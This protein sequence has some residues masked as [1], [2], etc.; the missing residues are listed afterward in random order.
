VAK[1]VRLI[2]S[3]S[4]QLVFLDVRLSDGLGFDVLRQLKQ[5]DFEL[6]CITAYDSYALEAFRFSAVDYL[7]K[8]IGPEEW[9]EALIRVRKRLTER[10][11]QGSI[12]ALLHNLSGNPNK[13]MSIP[14]PTGFDF[15]D[16]VDIVWCQSEGAYTAFHLT[17]GVTLLSSRNLGEYESMLC[18][19]RFF[20]IHNS[21]IVNCQYVKSY[22]KGR[23]GYV[24]MTDGA[25]LEVSQRRKA[26]FLK[27]LTL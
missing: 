7:L 3:T 11:S 16:L 10:S 8:P 17:T 19:G 5:R 14:T 15:I 20:R 22:M 23:G 13:K 24:L 21:I 4:P 18:N 6:I 26:D 12:A 2:E 27:K 9:E 1:A 25:E